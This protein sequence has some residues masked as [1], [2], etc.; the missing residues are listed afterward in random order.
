MAMTLAELRG[1]IEERSQK[2][3]FTSMQEYGWAVL[4]WREVADETD[5]PKYF[6]YS[7][8]WDALRQA[9]EQNN[10]K[11]FYNHMNRRLSKN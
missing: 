7:L 2:L 11:V 9:I 5:L 3:G 6:N 8:D 1:Y 4:N 10:P